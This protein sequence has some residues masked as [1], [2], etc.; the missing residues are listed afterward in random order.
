MP[1]KEICSFY[2]INKTFDGSKHLQGIY[3]IGVISQNI[4]RICSKIAMSLKIGRRNW[5]AIYSKKTYQWPTGIEYMKKFSTSLI[6]REMQ[7]KAMMRYCLTSVRMT[8]INNQHK[9]KANK[10]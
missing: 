10:I 4:E 5:I 8:T 7:I 2:K 3:L 6:I 1:W 9:K